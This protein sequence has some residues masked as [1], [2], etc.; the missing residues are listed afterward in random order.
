ME[1]LRQRLVRR[2]PL[3]QRDEQDN[4]VS[5]SDGEEEDRPL[6]YPHRRPKQSSNEIP[7]HREVIRRIRHLRQP[8]L[9]SRHPL[10]VDLKL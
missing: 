9:P 7:D 6:F 4:V 5:Q 10:A 2:K 1:L 3:V 8:P